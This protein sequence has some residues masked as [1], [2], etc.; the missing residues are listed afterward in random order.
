MS[1]EVTLPPQSPKKQKGT[2]PKWDKKKKKKKKEYGLREINKNI[3]NLEQKVAHTEKFIVSNNVKFDTGKINLIKL[4]LQLRNVE[5]KTVKDKIREEIEKLK[6][7]MKRWKKSIDTYTDDYIKFN[8]SLGKWRKRHK[9]IQG[10]QKEKILQ[11]YGMSPELSTDEMIKPVYPEQ[12]KTL[13]VDTEK[14]EWTD[15]PADFELF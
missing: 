8:K 4:E 6:K 9:K 14:G 15:L 10:K 3:K 5:E 12:L 2:D 7:S 11:K 1:F 13:K